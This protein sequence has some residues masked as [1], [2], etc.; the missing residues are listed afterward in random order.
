MM[1]HH[2]NLH[3]IAGEEVLRRKVGRLTE[4]PRDPEKKVEGNQTSLSKLIREMY[5]V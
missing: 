5:A 3:R 1:I 2:I 4:D